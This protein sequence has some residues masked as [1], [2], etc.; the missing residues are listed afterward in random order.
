MWYKTEGISEETLVV[1]LLYCIEN[2]NCKVLTELFFLFLKVKN[3]PTYNCTECSCIFKSLG[4]LHT[5]IS[6]M[7]MSSTQ[8]TASST[9]ETSH[10]TTVTFAF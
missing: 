8:N 3:G 1:S 2:H 4:S 6:K 10:I 7:H 5:H 9:A